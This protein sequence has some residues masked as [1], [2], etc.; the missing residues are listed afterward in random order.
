MSDVLEEARRRK[1]QPSPFAFWLQ[2]HEDLLSLDFKAATSQAMLRRIADE[3]AVA[4]DIIDILSDFFSWTDYRNRVGGNDVLLA[5]V[6]QRLAADDFRK[7]LDD[8]RF[9]LDRTHRVINRLRKFGAGKRAWLFAIYFNNRR[10]IVQSF[11]KVSH[12]YGEPA[13]V[14]VLGKDTIG[15]WQ[16]VLAPV[17]TLMRLSIALPVCLLLIALSLTDALMDVNQTP[18]VVFIGLWVATAM[19][20]VL[21]LV[22]AIALIRNFWRGRAFPYLRHRFDKLRQALHLQWVPTEVWGIAAL[23]LLAAIAW[24]WP[25]NFV[26]WPFYAAILIMSSSIFSNK[27]M[28]FGCVLATATALMFVMETSVVNNLRLP[29]L[30]APA[31]L[32]GARQLH[33][34]AQTFFPKMRLTD[35]DFVALLGSALGLLFIVLTAYYRP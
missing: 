31:T 32:W 2:H 22:E 26:Q 15:F 5:K 27:V 20:A 3:G 10:D 4:R 21:F 29:F 14:D 25:G 1:D 30:L 18:P 12:L 33:R 8:K 9:R 19:A 6:R 11:R 13:V 7:W 28:L 23:S 34:R 24:W 17:P 35:R 16:R